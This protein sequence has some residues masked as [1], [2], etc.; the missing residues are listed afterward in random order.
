MYAR[1]TTFRVHPEKIDDAR[2]LAEEMKPEIMAIPGIKYWF[3]TGNEDGNGVVIAIYET[4]EAAEAAAKTASAMF[5]RFAEF[6]ESEPQSQ[7]FEV[8]LHGAN[9]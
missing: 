9:T 1:I 8:L 3:D 2:A 4:T 7:G 6:M 5:G